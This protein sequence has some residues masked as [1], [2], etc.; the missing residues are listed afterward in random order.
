ETLVTPAYLTVFLN[1]IVLHN[2]KELQG[3]TQHRTTAA[4]TPHAATGP[5]EL[6]DHGDLVRFRNIWVRPLTGYDA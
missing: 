3:P 6:Q 5:L 2:R 4:Y 1:G